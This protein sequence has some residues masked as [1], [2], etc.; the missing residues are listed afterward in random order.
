MYQYVCNQFPTEE[1]DFPK[2]HDCKNSTRIKI[3][4]DISLHTLNYLLWINCKLLELPGQSVC[5]NLNW[6]VNVQF[7]KNVSKY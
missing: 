7:I 6:S 4:I 1:H 3:L 2:S 5:E